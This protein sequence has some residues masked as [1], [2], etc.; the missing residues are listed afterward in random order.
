MSKKSNTL[1]KVKQISVSHNHSWIDGKRY[2]N[3]R[4]YQGNQCEGTLYNIE[5]KS[6]RTVLVSLYQLLHNIGS[7]A[8]RANVHQ[9]GSKKAKFLYA[10]NCTSI[11]ILLGNIRVWDTYDTWPY[12]QCENKNML[13]KYVSLYMHIFKC[14][15]PN[16]SIAGSFPL[17]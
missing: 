13:L 7:W 17:I 11:W 10:L 12:V 1:S 3:F 15:F 2:R 16:V 8:L 14:V 4:R 5:Y 6:L 9:C